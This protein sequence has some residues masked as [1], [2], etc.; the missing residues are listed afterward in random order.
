M[1]AYTSFIEHF[2]GN[3][4]AIILVPVATNFTTLLQPLMND[5]MPSNRF[6]MVNRFAMYEMPMCW[7]S[8]QTHTSYWPMNI[9]LYAQAYWLQWFGWDPF[10]PSNTYTHAHTVQCTYW[11]ED[12]F[13][14]H[15]HRN[16]IVY[17][18]RRSDWCANRRRR[19]RRNCI[20]LLEIEQNS[21]SMIRRP[22]NCRCIHSS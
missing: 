6:E 8:E 19:R 22:V 11:I 18:K 2:D 5:I 3:I 9:R 10:S 14:S 7:I 16:V 21:S 1:R 12:K 20:C 17:R 15:R 13:N 4:L